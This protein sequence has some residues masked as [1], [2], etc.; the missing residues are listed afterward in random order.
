MLLFVGH[1]TAT[2]FL[3]IS[4]LIKKK[5]K[6]LENIERNVFFFGKGFLLSVLTDFFDYLDVQYFNVYCV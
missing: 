1:N 3:F 2:T 6:Y 5:F 4:F